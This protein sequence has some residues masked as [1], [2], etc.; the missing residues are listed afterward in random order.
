M[1]GHER[2]T[3]NRYEDVSPSAG[4]RRIQTGIA[5]LDDVLGGGLPQGHLYLV[6]GDPGTGKTTLALQSAGWD[7][8]GRKCHL[9]NPVGIQKG[10]GRGCALPRLAHRLT[11]HF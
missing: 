6:E 10:A 9:C 11:E 5:G 1:N 7:S 8:A 3:T 2:R 4:W